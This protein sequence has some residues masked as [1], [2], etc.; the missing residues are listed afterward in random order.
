MT[1]ELE[2]LQFLHFHPLS[3]RMEITRGISNAPSDSTMKRV[4]SAAVKNG[5][6]ET[7][8]RGPATK[9]RLTPQ[10]LVTMPLNLST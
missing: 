1:I 10:A 4:I 3:N 6:V 9:Y 5:F 8:G 2:V 7:F